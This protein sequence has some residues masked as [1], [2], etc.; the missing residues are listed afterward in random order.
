L[1]AS[2]DHIFKEDRHVFAPDNV[3]RWRLMGL[4]VRVRIIPLLNSPK[5]QIFGPF[6][7]L[8]IF[9][10]TRFTIRTI[11]SKLPLIIIVAPWKLYS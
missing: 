5:P 6:L 7:D 10:R 9:A 8:E 2:G 11:R 4:I 3:F 1:P